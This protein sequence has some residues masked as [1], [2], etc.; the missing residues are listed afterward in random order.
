MRCCSGFG[1]K[2]GRCPQRKPQEHWVRSERERR[3]PLPF[4]NDSRLSSLCGSLLLAVGNAGSKGLTLERCLVVCCVQGAFGQACLGA[5]YTVEGK[6]THT[7]LLPN[8]AEAS[9]FNGDFRVSVSHS[10]WMITETRDRQGKRFE[11]YTGFDGTNV[12]QLMRF[13][14]A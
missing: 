7:E 5:D 1:A 12:F 14:P 13:P 2:K 3:M 6:I 9:R 10:N 4:R 8:G 11:K